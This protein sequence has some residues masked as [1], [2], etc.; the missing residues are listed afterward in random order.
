MPGAEWFCLKQHSQMTPTDSAGL[1][2]VLRDPQPLCIC[3]CIALPCLICQEKLAK[4]WP[5]LQEQ[6]WAP[7]HL[8]W[9]EGSEHKSQH[10][11]H[12]AMHHSRQNLMEKLRRQRKPPP[13]LFLEITIHCFFFIRIAFPSPNL[14]L[15]GEMGRRDRADEGDQKEKGCSQK[16]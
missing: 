9:Q 6:L 5:W 14:C 2:H 3:G 11:K 1:R 16:K 15:S 4:E 12:K 8:Y 13:P 7:L 10:G